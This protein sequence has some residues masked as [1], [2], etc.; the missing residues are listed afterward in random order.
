M[1]ARAVWLWGTL[2]NL[3]CAD[4]ALAEKLYKT[5]YLSFVAEIWDENLRVANAARRLGSGAAGSPD[6]PDA[7][8][9]DHF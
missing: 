8:S 1:V 5:S 2:W 4:T 7:Q 3:R 6:P 9:H